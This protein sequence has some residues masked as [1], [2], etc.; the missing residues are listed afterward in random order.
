VVKIYR[1]SQKKFTA[2]PEVRQFKAI[3]ELVAVL[4]KNIADE[5]YR[6][7]IIP[8][9][10][11]CLQWCTNDVRM[12][13]PSLFKL[14]TDLTPHQILPV[15]TE[16]LRMHKP[17]YNAGEIEISRYDGMNKDKLEEVP[18]PITVIADNLRS[19]YNLGAIYRTAECVQARWMYFCGITPFPPMNAF[20][21]SSMGTAERVPYSVYPTETAIE[22]CKEKGLPVIALETVLNSKCLFDYHPTQPVAVILG[23]E[24]LGIEESILKLADEVLYIPVF[25]W[26]NSLNVSNAFTLAAY[27]LSGVIQKKL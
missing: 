13:F 21:K 26:K 25:G 6:R 1:Y 12:H 14:S 7:Q 15:L 5:D 20:L 11:E 16:A 23:N 3:L 17:H 4:E 10:L 19:E 18:Y 22:L 8:A 2:F 9:I 24:A 27:W